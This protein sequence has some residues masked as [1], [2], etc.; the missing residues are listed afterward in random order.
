MTDQIAGHEIT[1]HKFAG[2]KNARYEIAGHVNT[3]FKIAGQKL[4]LAID[5]ISPVR[6]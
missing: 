1:G 5:K 2:H 3:R 4:N 6:D